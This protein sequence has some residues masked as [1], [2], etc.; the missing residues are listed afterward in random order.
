[1][2]TQTVTTIE[3]ARDMPDRSRVVAHLEVRLPGSRGNLSSAFSLTG[4]VF[5][6][7]GNLSGGARAKRYARLLANGANTTAASEPDAC[8][9]VHD[10]IL[11]AFPSL[12]RFAAMHLADPLT[13]E[14]MHALENGWYWYAG[15]RADL[16]ATERYTGFSGVYAHQLAERGLTSTDPEEYTDDTYARETYCHQVAREILRVDYIPRDLD[17]AGFGRFVEGLRELWAYEAADARE[18]VTVAALLQADNPREAEGTWSV[19]DL[20]SSSGLDV[21][22]VRRVLKLLPVTDRYVGG[23]FG[24]LYGLHA[25]TASWMDNQVNA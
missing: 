16:R 11:R 14:P 3:L 7:R 18:L 8:G 15:S 24:H 4:E 5:E 6:P 22:T 19:W 1:M 9:C 10:Q 23:T 25:V 12:A 21:I 17:R 2:S 20:H 13:G